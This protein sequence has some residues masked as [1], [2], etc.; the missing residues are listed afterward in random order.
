MYKKPAT[1]CGFSELGVEGGI[2]SR[3]PWR[4]PYGQPSAVQNGYPA[5]LSK[6]G[7]SHPPSHVSFNFSFNHKKTR[8]SVRDFKTWRRGRDSNPRKV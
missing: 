8:N 3:R 5:I 2:H 4:S 7:G 1:M 6:N